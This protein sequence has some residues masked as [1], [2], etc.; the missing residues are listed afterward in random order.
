MNEALTIISIVIA[1][2]VL[3][4][5]I[6]K[7]SNRVYRYYMEKDLVKDDDLTGCLIPIVNTIIAL[8]YLTVALAVLFA[9]WSIH[10]ENKHPEVKEALLKMLR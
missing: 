10:R 4:I 2:Y 8:I 1:I 5:V 6:L 9:V 7:L 3:S